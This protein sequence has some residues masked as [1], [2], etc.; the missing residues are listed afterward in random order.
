MAGRRRASPPSGVESGPV[1]VEQIGADGDGIA[2]GPEGRTLFLANTLRGEL[3]QPG[4]LTKRGDGFAADAVI[5]EASADRVEPPCPHFGPCGGCTLQH[6]RD[7]SYAQWKLARASA[8]GVQAASLAR[9]PSGARRRMDFAIRREGGAIRV[10]LHRRRSAEIVDIRA[11]PVLHPALFGLLQALRPVLARLDGLRKQGEARV[12]L[13]D[14]GPDLLLHTDA[15]LSARDRIGLAALA[16]AQ[17]M[18]RVT[19]SDGTGKEP[20]AVL[21]PATTAFS[22]VVTEIPPGAFL[23]ASREGEAA[24][25][26]AVLRALPEKIGGE[27]VELFAGC[28]TLT[29]ALSG[30]G[31][32]VA[33]EGDAD[34]VAALRR[35]GNQRVTAVQR[36]LARQPLMA[37]EL[38][39]A[40]VIV[41]DP[42]YGG[43]PLLMPALAGCAVPIVYVSCNPMALAR[44]GRALVRHRARTVEAIDQFLW[45]TQTETV[46]AF[47]PF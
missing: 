19:W 42:P 46:T 14:S 2:V 28:G 30:R 21:R 20:A 4:A 34:A 12:N 37:A 40:A 47:L 29:H 11:C 44:D 1:R 10:G 39:R 6:W 18:P 33:Y 3:V 24:I 36:D 13:L 16:Q 35:A 5:L 25:V 41:L 23:Q 8:F 45:S 32:V 15:P 31:R 7:E 26:A 9:T 38:K 17:G 27:I 22:G 43:A